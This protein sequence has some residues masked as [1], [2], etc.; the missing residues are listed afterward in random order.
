MANSVMD[1][2]VSQLRV[3][4][5]QLRDWPYPDQIDHALSGHS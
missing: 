2:Y 4:L 1:D 5:H 3:A